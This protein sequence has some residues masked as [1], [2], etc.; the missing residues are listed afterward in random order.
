LL[1]LFFA[2]DTRL[3]GAFL[4]EGVGFFIPAPVPLL[5]RPDLVLVRTEGFSMMA[6]AWKTKSV[7]AEL[8]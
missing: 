8:S 7:L 3:V 2:G 6:S 1:G 5:T 4:P